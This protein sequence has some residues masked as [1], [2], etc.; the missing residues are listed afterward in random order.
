MARQH[1]SGEDLQHLEA[2]IFKTRR[3]LRSTMAALRARL[4]GA[5]RQRRTASDPAAAAPVADPAWAGSKPKRKSGGLGAAAV[6][7]GIAGL[8]M[9]VPRMIRKRLDATPR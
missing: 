5:W 3:D 7:G 8:S 2:S 1:R 4:A 6:I 9:V